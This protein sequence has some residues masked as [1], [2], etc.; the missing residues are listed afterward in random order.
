MDTFVLIRRVISGKFRLFIILLLFILA[1]PFR[2]SVAHFTHNGFALLPHPLLRPAGRRILILIDRGNGRETFDI[3]LMSVS[4][5]SSYF[6]SRDQL[7]SA[8]VLAG[9]ITLFNC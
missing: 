5:G 7:F 6:G 8:L 3:V 4:R 1:R 2:H 9:E